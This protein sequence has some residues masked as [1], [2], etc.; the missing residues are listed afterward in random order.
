L[1]KLSILDQ[2]PIPKGHTA[3][4]A[5]RAS[6]ELAKHA[7]QWGYHRY[8]LAEHHNTGGLA[9]SSPEILIS[10]LAAYTKNLR[11]GSGGVLLS[12]YSPYKVAE[13][14]RTLEALYPGRIDLGI[15]RAPGGSPL[16]GLALRDGQ[17]RQPQEFPRLVQDVKNLL[18]NKTVTDS[19]LDGI[20]ATPYSETR[21]ELWLLG[22]SD[23]SAILAAE[24]GTSFSFAHFINGNGGPAVV[25]DYYGRFQPSA[26]QQD[27]KASV[28]VFVVCAET[29][30][31]AMKEAM[32][33]EYWLLLIAQGKADEGVPSVEE[34]TV[35]EPIDWEMEQMRDN[36]RRM[37][38]G[39]PETVKAGLEYMAEEYGTDELMI[40]TNLHN[41]AARLNSYRLLAE[42]FRLNT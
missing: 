13:T 42:V 22:S 24:A 18:L 12:H 8:W 30:E 20:Y 39:S 16:T 34:A 28:C 36:R 11:M 10:H 1:L 17:Q 32:S 27:P 41:Q 26:Y 14:F 5:L 3:E 29:D 4:E 15:G 33:L 2:V 21:P 6:L 23:A 7:D 38:V 35:F 19:R 25:R 37:I 40:I 9:S 31:K